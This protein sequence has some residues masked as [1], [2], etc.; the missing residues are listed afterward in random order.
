MLMWLRQLSVMMSLNFESY[1]TGIHKV[2]LQE[3]TASKMHKG[4]LLQ[5]G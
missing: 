4:S 2:K 3:H 1:D 5:M